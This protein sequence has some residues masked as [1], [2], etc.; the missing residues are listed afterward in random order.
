MIKAAWNLRI[1]HCKSTCVTENKGEHNTVSLLSFE[2]RGT[3]LLPAVTLRLVECVNKRLCWMC[4]FYVFWKYLSSWKWWWKR[5]NWYG[6]WCACC[7]KK[8][9][10][11]F[12]SL[13]L[14]WWI[15]LRHSRIQSWNNR[16]D[17]MICYFK[18]KSVREN[19]RNLTW[20]TLLEESSYRVCC[21]YMC[22]H[23]FCWKATWLISCSLL[24]LEGLQETAE[25]RREAGPHDVLCSLWV[26]IIT[27]FLQC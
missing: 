3:W 7:P 22:I 20:S 21:I 19:F 26:C 18:P 5:G 24:A 15:T 16:D 10:L 23:V 1:H 6:G 2:E 8:K 17:V 11:P 27:L 13:W 25:E 9:V 12:L 14:I 4:D